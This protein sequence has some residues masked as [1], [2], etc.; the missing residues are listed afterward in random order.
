MREI[1]PNELYHHGVLGMKWGI[2]R[3][4]NYDG[5]YTKKGLERYRKSESAYNE[6]KSK[7]DQAKSNFKAAKREAFEKDDRESLEKIELARAKRQD[8]KIGL[9]NAKNDLSRKYDQVKR[10]KL[11]DKG[12]NLYNK[13]KTITGNNR[14]ADT[15]TAIGVGTLY[16]GRKMAATY[17]RT[18]LSDFLQTIGAGISIGGISTRLSNIAKNRQL[19]AY[20]SHSRKD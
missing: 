18:N 3:Y 17:G 6:A 8:A 10:D 5:T 15:I 12:K 16:V 19:R 9:K 20:Y 11:A 2:R 4:Q 13:G 14:E 1:Y 7:Y